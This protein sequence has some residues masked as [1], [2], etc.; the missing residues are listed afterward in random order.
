MGGIITGYINQTE[1]VYKRNDSYAKFLIT[2][3][4]RTLVRLI[5]SSFLIKKDRSFD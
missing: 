3:C 4:K 2:N 1:G 5:I